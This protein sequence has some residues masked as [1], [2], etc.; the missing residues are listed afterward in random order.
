MN[1]DLNETL[2]EGFGRVTIKNR[3]IG[4]AATLEEPQITFRPDI[5]L[6]L[7]KRSR[8]VA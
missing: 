7:S 1:K 8:S 2:G 3:S 6:S 4:I 5:R